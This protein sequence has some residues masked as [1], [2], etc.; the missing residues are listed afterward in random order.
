VSSKPNGLGFGLAICRTIARAHGGTLA[1]DESKT[2][3]ACIVLTLPSPTMLG[4]KQA[5]N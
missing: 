2:G 5:P 1:F 4:M 3:G